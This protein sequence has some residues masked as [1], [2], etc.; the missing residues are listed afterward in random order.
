[1]SSHPSKRVK[2]WRA[3]KVQQDKDHRW[4]QQS[5]DAE[6]LV[7]TSELSEP[8]FGRV[9]AQFGVNL[10]VEDEQGH[11]HHCLTRRN[12]PRLV[13]GDH[14]MWCSA[15]SGSDIV[16]ELLERKTLLARPNYQQQLKPIAANIDLIFIVAAPEPALDEDLIN[17]YLVATTLTEITPIILINKID[18]LSE[19]ELTLLKEK[20]SM[21]EKLDYPVLFLSNEKQI[22]VNELKQYFE[23]KI[24]IFVGQSGVG[25][26]SIIQSLLPERSLRIGEL[27]SSTGLGKHTTSVTV[28]Y[29]V[30]KKGGIIDSPGIREFGLGHVSR[31]VIAQGFREFLPLLPYCKFNDCKHLKEPGCAIKAATKDG[32]ISQR[33]FDSFQRIVLSLGSR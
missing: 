7:N 17:R 29:P 1:M 25:K 20:M 13:C 23:E 11:I 12:I 33:R 16:V 22:G 14:V 26:S 19:H 21:Y 18:L 31:E 4:Q 9:V 3:K 5:S 30:N 32:S 28:L 24:G 8:Q 10:Q 27:S 6:Q 15:T 2:A